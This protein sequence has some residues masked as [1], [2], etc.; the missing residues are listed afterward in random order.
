MPSRVPPRTPIFLER[1]RYELS[2][3]SLPDRT[4]P[5]FGTRRQNQPRNPTSPGG[6]PRV[7]PV[8]RC[9]TKPGVAAG[10]SAPTRGAN[11]GD[12]GACG[13]ACPRPCGGAAMRR[14]ETSGTSNIGLARRALV[15]RLAV[16]QPTIL[17]GLGRGLGSDAGV[18][19]SYPQRFRA[20][21]ERPCLTF[22]GGE[23]RSRGATPGVCPDAR[24]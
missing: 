19:P 20:R 6:V 1:T 9:R 17:R 18:S 2:R 16:A 3:Y 14:R 21:A 7:R 10:R 22:A 23:A 4:V 24:L 15:A 13:T 5:G 11:T 12:L 8:A